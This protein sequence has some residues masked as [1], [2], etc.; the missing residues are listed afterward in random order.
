MALSNKGVC[1]AITFVMKR[2]FALQEIAR[3]I[4]LN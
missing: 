2:A 4:P 1:H 3:R